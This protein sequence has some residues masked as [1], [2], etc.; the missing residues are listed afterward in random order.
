MIYTDEKQNNGETQFRG[1]YDNGEKVYIRDN[2]EVVFNGH[3]QDEDGISVPIRV[4]DVIHHGSP[5]YHFFK[6]INDLV[7]IA[8]TLNN[9]NYLKEK[10]VPVVIAEF[11]RGVPSTENEAWF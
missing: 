8:I 7:I 4:H 9:V 2:I 5:D 11:N 10:G 1:K 6:K 3:D